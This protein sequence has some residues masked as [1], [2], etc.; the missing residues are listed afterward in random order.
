MVDPADR[1]AASPA[2]RLLAAR[3]RLV[4]S[5]PRAVA[6]GLALRARRRAAWA[7]WPDAAE[8]AQAVD[9]AAA[10]TARFMR[11]TFGASPA[12]RRPLV[13]AARALV[14]PLS[15]DLARCGALLEPAAPGLAARAL[16]DVLGGRLRDARLVLF[17]PSG[18]Q[19]AKA[20]CFVFAAGAS[21]PDAVVLAMA[22]PRWSERL[23][24]ETDLVEDL[25]ARLAGAPHV[26]H[27]LPL[28]P[29]A[30]LELGHDLAVVARADPLA[31]R[32][33]GVVAPDR[34]RAWSWLRDFHA[35]TTVRTTSW[36]AHE[37]EEAAQALRAA[38]VEPAPAVEGALRGPI[39]CPLPVCAVHGDFW[40]GNIA[41]DER[42]LRVFDWEWGALEG[43]PL[44]D[45]WSYEL[46]DAQFE[47]H[48]PPDALAERLRGSLERIRAEL[49][50]RGLDP[51]LAAAALPATLAELI[52][53]FPRATG[54][55]GSAEPALRRL[56]APIEQVLAEQ[57]G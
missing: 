55:A 41:H 38:G 46:S 11:T 45:L 17:S 54:R 3:G 14:D 23:R 50:R 9:V 27:A 53:R 31:A 12:S 21:A 36:S 25:R 15:W 29:L 22:D 20:V 1:A 48:R 39:G 6:R 13:D 49:D 51:R 42:S 18:S 30:R 35:A 7:I 4:R 56:L 33:G 34:E 26:A 19:L 37:A 40:S 44:L 24:H 10:A 5:R 57:R 32:T 2:L 8:P 47:S 43:G 28:E 16:E 52:L